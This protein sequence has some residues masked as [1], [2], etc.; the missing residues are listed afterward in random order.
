MSTDIR[1][2]LADAAARPRREVDARF[3]LDRARQQV[4]RRRLGAAAL[5]LLVVVPLGAQ[6]ARVLDRE[7]GRRDTV[8]AALHPGTSTYVAGNRN[9]LPVPDPGDVVPAV[10][11][12]GARVFVVA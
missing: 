3:V 12:D 1:D 9:S 5:A 10:L 4:Q 7:P 2:V 8:A 6:V 11:N